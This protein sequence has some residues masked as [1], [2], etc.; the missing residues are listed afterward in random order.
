MKDRSANDTPP[1]PAL[2]PP[3]EQERLDSWKQIAAY[4]GKS[5]RTVH[6]WHQTEGL[7]INRHVH[8]QKASV[9]VYRS[10][11]DAWLKSRQQSSTADR[12]KASRSQSVLLIAAAAIVAIVPSYTRSR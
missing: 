1:P 11:L 6:R 4:L 10:Q 5:E 3:Q 2:M 8:Q 9:W 7:P 12:P